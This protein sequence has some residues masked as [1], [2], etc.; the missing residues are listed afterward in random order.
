[1]NYYIIQAAAE[2]LLLSK[3]KILF[4]KDKKDSTLRSKCL[5]AFP[6]LKLAQS[7]VT[8]DDIIRMISNETSPSVIVSG[9]IVATKL[10]SKENNAGVNARLLVLARRVRFY[11]I[12][13]EIIMNVK[14]VYKANGRQNK[15]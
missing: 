3:L 10:A 15:M 5:T 11:Y 7:D 14:L 2:S 8:I 4:I 9:L 12:F 1:M 13:S 6:L